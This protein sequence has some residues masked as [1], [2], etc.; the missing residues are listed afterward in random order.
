MEGV[1]HLHTSILADAE[2]GM[3]LVEQAS[4]LSRSYLRPGGRAINK[5][6][7]TPTDPNG[8]RAPSVG[9]LYHCGGVLGWSFA[10]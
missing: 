5:H 10:V 4:E 8:S 2:Y 3:R 1:W 7:W 6:I 9:C